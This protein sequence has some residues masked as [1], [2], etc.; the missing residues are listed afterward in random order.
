MLNVQIT[1]V[2][3]FT[4]KYC[5]LYFLYLSPMMRQVPV[6]NW[7]RTSVAVSYTHLDVYK[8]QVVPRALCVTLADRSLTVSA[9]RALFMPLP[10]NN[11]LNLT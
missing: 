8:R 1:S 9:T 2:Y 10:H 11:Y 4:I 7:F 6:F 5:L 3:S